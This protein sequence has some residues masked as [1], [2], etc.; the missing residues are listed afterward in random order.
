MKSTFTTFLKL[1]LRTHINIG[2]TYV[3]VVAIKQDTVVLWSKSS[4]LDRKV[5]GSN[6]AAANIT[7]LT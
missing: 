7:N 6:P 4:T 1:C 2:S 5:E 3:N